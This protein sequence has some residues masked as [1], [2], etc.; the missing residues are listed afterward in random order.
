MFLSGVPAIAETDTP[1][2]LRHPAQGV[3]RTIIL[4]G[5]YDGYFAVNDTK[6]KLTLWWQ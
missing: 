2:S 6:G 1:S 4:R 5:G 3:L